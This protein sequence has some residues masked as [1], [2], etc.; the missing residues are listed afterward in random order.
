MKEVINFSV[1]AKSLT[2]P[3]E[4]AERFEALS[5][6][7]VSRS[8][9]LWG[10]HC[11]ECGFPDCYSS[12]SFYTP[13][14][15]YHCRRFENGLQT[16]KAGA[17]ALTSVTF[18][19][20]GKMEAEGP[21]SILTRAKADQHE[22]A[23]ARK[24]TLIDKLPVSQA[25]RNKLAWRVNTR[26]QAG[27]TDTGTPAGAFIIEAYMPTEAPVAFT[28]SF[29]PNSKDNPNFFQMGFELS[30]GY[31]LIEVPAAQIAERVNLAENYLI[32]IEPVTE[33]G[34]GEI[35]F[36]LVD[37]ATLEKHIAKKASA[38]SATSPDTFASKVKCVVWD[39]DHTVWDGTLAE[40]GIEGLTIKPEVVTMMHKLDARGILNSIASKNDEEIGLKALEHF[41]LRDLV[42]YPQIGWHPKSQSLKTIAKSIDIG[43]DT[44][45][46]LDDQKFERAEVSENL[47]MVE[48]LDATEAAAL[49]G[50][51]RFD[52]PATDEAAK[53]REKYK[54][55]EKRVSTFVE[56]GQEYLSFLKGCDIQLKLLPLTDDRL[57]R[58]FEL[59]QRTNQLN[60][61]GQ[62]YERQQLID[63]QG[64]PEDYDVTLLQCEDRFGDYGIIGLSVLNRKTATLES[65]MMSCRV[66]R[67]MVEHAYFG[68]LL[69]ALKDAGV[70][71]L[72]VNFRKTE[73]NDASV[74]MLEDLG[75]EAIH[76]DGAITGFAKATQSELDNQGIVAIVDTRTMKTSE[77]A[78]S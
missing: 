72:C 33:A 2:L 37:F 59:S 70:P 24:S 16:A 64:A 26:A 27:G 62:R 35:I 31:N 49:L 36:G 50:R 51:D 63:M 45:V 71:Q 9:F 78:A 18:K 48:C 65:F 39:L 61:S 15:D 75:F 7:I 1:P 5:A 55:E 3:A 66:Q 29:M 11:T 4:I 25:I 34:T 13:R 47:T 23:H 74:R 43:L 69:T 52:V 67:K 68:T 56:S 22:A 46:F 8:T 21:V 40:D 10:E 60:F 57:D 14:Q 58:A 38:P 32:Q 53:R 41:G 20:W 76:E 42:L 30:A 17:R 6:Q 54:D 77:V 28:L 73:R 44:F 12:C 19:M